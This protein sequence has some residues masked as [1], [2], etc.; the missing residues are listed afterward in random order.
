MRRI[1][2]DETKR[3]PRERWEAWCDSFT[4]G[5]QG[6]LVDIEVID[7]EMGPK[8]LAE[9]AVLV[10]IDYDPPDKGNDFVISYGDA[11]SPFR[12][13][14]LGPVTLWQAQDANGLVVSLEIED[15]QGNRT[16]LS[17]G[18]NTECNE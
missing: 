5:N 6:R 18:W 3:I 7:A 13:V 14:I 12:H 11:A 8:P 9:H 10:A 1:A 17:L 4:N 2:P 15:Q 16:I